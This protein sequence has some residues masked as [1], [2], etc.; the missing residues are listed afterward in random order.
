MNAPKPNEMASYDLLKVLE[1]NPSLSQRDL[2][3]HLG[4][5]LGK[6]NFCLKA[7]IQKGCLKVSN[8]RN[9][10]NKLAYAYLLTPRGVEERARMTVTF[11]Q[12]KMQEYDRPQVEIDEL[13]LE[14]R[15]KGLIGHDVE[16]VDIPRTS[17]P[18]ATV[19]SANH[20]RTGSQG[21][22]RQI[23]KDGKQY[24]QG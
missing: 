24:A 2:A 5:S 1:E 12:Y 16:P 3:N 17:G 15:Q 8:F 23:M 14:A 11:L 19:I 10:D 22:W 4:I 20:G 6:V 9:S 13:Q 18:E 21:R 7:L